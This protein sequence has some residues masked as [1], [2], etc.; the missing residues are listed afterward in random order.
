M[1]K[2]PTEVRKKINS[3]LRKL[4]VTKKLIIKCGMKYYRK[5]IKKPYG[6]QRRT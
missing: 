5:A 4:L 3:Y 2:T 6:N 1:K